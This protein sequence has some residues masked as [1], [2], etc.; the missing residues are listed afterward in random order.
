MLSN[1][2]RNLD[3]MLMLNPSNL[4]TL[5]PM[6]MLGKYIMDILLRIMDTADTMAIP[7]DTTTNTVTSARDPLMLNPTQQ[8]PRLDTTIADITVDTEDTIGIE[9]L[10]K[11]FKN[12]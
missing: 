7:T 11:M 1:N 4:R 9:L 6:L 3:P 8:G 12:P 5:D 10:V 2:L